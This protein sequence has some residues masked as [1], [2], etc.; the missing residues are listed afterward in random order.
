MRIGIDIRELEKGKKTGI[1]RILNAFLDYISLNDTI[2]EYILF[3]NQKVELQVKRISKKNIKIIIIR[4]RVT[5]IWDQIILPL[6]LKKAKVDLF[7][8]PYFKA[9]LFA[10]CSFITMISDLTPLRSPGVKALSKFYY[11]FWG[12][13]C[14]KFAKKVITPSQY[15][16]QDLINTLGLDERKIEIVSP[17]VEDHFFTSILEE[18]VIKIHKKYKIKKPYILWIGIARPSKNLKSLI[19]AYSKLPIEIQDRYDLVLASKKNEYLKKLKIL[20][21]TIGL[22]NKVLFPGFIDDKDLGPLYYAAELFVFPSLY[23]GF[24]IPP[25][26]AMA[27]GTPVVA[28]NTASLPEVLENAAVLVDP[29]DTEELSQKISNILTDSNQSKKLIQ[30][31]L[32]R[33]KNFSTIKCARDLL[34]CLTS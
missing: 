27:C 26:E 20:I 4:E 25:I 7:F 29:L 22:E 19:E 2:N 31:G 21:K 18:D 30:R 28:A 33:S 8:S 13:L 32:E 9:P 6:A 17:G 16:K 34:K 23:E 11:S 24:G 3:G 1:S 15:S 5:F 10:S 14:A 12:R